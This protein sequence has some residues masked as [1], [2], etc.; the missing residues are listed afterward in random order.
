MT[1]QQIFDI[2]QNEVDLNIEEFKVLCETKVLNDNMV[3]KINVS[4]RKLLKRITDKI[5]IDFKN[6]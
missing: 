1:I 6:E 4:N 5:K 2:I 3:L